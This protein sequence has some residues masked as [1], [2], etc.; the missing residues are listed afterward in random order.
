MSEEL[1]RQL[2]V[3]TDKL[4]AISARA[5]SIKARCDK[6]NRSLAIG[7]RTLREGRKLAKKVHEH[8]RLLAACFAEGRALVAEKD[9]LV[10]ALGAGK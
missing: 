3:V 10:A 5:A 2:K 8:G 9:R 4:S 7:P 6:V 1:E